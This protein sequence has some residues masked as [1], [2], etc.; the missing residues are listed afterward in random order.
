MEADDP[1]LRSVSPF[2]IVRDLRSAVHFY[3]D[4]LGFQSVLELPEEDPFFA[5]V[6]RD[7][8]SF[9]LKEIGPDT[10]PVPNYTRHEWARWDAFVDTRRW[11][12]VGGG[13]PRWTADDVEL[14]RGEENCELAR[15]QFSGDPGRLF[16]GRTNRLLGLRVTRKPRPMGCG[17]GGGPAHVRTPSRRQEHEARHCREQDGLQRRRHDSRDKRCCESNEAVGCGQW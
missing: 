6:C 13:Q 3:C 11:S 15:A 5:V 7:T 10:S 17:D 8:V 9:S 16:P 2:F 12:P 4:K 14:S 1:L